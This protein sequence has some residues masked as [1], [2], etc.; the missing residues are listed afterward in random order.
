MQ[1]SEI[2]G[3]EDIK[4]QLIS[5]IKKNKV[6]HAQLFYS[7]NGNANLAMAIAYATY[8]NCENKQD[9]DSCGKCAA[10]SKNNKLIHPDLHFIYPVATSKKVDKNPSS[11]LYMKDW[12][13]FVANQ[14]YGSIKEWGEEMG[15]EN[16]QPNIAAEEARNIVK[17]ISLKA[18]EGEFK[19][20]IIWLPEYM[21]Q[22][23]G[24]ALLKTLE[25]P[26]EKT[27]FLL[28]ANN[29]EKLLTTI[30][31]RTQKIMIRGFEKKEIT[32]YLVE[33]Y[34]CSLDRAE[35]IAFIADGSMNEA[36][37]L[38]NKEEEDHHEMFRVWLRNCYSF[39]VKELT[40]LS[41]DFQ[42]L[43]R[44]AQKTLLIYGINIIRE[45]LLIQAAPNLSRLRES[46]KEFVE[47]FSKVTNHKILE[48]IIQFYNK[49]YFHIERNANPKILFADL[50]FQIALAL[51]SKK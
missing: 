34:N 28:V 49:A 10:C 39:K 50:S 51:R 38:T 15:I 32:Q 6:P 16:K 41:D 35:S 43:G 37:Q 45:C 13:Q 24:N 9:N 30:L 4:N 40:S 12:R 1:F 17:K 48:D 26:P 5:A 7:N 25:E 29:H 27:V 36:I 47:K 44:E 20:L 2:P 42:S 46:E 21:N 31:S 14:P 22:A 11:N 19:I 23:S 18:F 8:L 3:L 33:R